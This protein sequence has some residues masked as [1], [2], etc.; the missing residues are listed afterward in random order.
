MDAEMGTV[1]SALAAV[2]GALVG[3][4][5]TALVQQ[6][7]EAQPLKDR[8]FQQYLFQLK[9][10]VDS[11]WHRFNKFKTRPMGLLRQ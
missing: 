4:G 11:L 10:A 9:D 5:V 6:P 8:L 2:L 1:I 3:S 7:K